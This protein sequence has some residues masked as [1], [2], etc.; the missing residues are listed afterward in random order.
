MIKSCAEL[1]HSSKNVLGNKHQ[2]CFI[3]LFG[4][5]I[6]RRALPFNIHDVHLTPVN[7][8]QVA[9]VPHNAKTILKFPH[10]QLF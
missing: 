9:R 4:F 3:Q 8:R 5:S 1:T 10:Q 2:V 7:T 6:L